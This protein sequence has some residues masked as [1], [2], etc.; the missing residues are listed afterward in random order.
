MLFTVSNIG[1]VIAAKGIE[2][3]LG[4]GQLSEDQGNVARLE[5]TIAS[6]AIRNRRAGE[7]LLFQPARKCFRL[8]P[9]RSLHIKLLVV[10]SRRDEAK[11]R[12]GD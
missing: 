4:L 12:P 11:V 2:I 3:D 6:I 7:K 5:W 8:R 10:L 9:S 1:D